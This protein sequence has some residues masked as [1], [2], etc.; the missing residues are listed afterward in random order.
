MLPVPWHHPFGALASPNWMRMAGSSPKRWR[1]QEPDPQQY[2]P[3]QR[4]ARRPTGGHP[5]TASACLSTSHERMM[6]TRISM[7]RMFWLKSVSLPAGASRIR[8]L[9]PL[10]AFSRLMMPSDPYSH[11]HT[12][13]SSVASVE[14]VRPECLRLLWHLGSP[15]RGRGARG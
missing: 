15:D 13:A 10:C 2:F 7:N 3:H 14:T 9:R 4:H 1:T 11:W 6:Q 5:G 12:S 8:N